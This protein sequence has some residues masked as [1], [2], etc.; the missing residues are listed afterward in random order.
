MFPVWKQ[1]FAFTDV[2]LLCTRT[3]S[4]LH[5]WSWSSHLICSSELQAA[6]CP[7][8][9]GG[10][11]DKQIKERKDVGVYLR[12]HH[13]DVCICVCVCTHVYA[14][15]F[16]HFNIHHVWLNIENH[17]GFYVVGIWCENMGSVLMEEFSYPLFMCSFNK[18]L[19]RMITP[20]LLDG[21]LGSRVWTKPFCSLW[22]NRAVVLK[23]WAPDKT[24][25]AFPGTVLKCMCSTQCPLVPELQNEK[26]WGWVPA[27]YF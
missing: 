12:D 10:L 20:S 15:V 6:S 22:G 17:L 11:I 24:T 7:V 25:S 9:F 5:G 13:R 2:C 19:M 26:L 4:W 21:V 14:I 16:F 3:W 18:C 1:T 27:I 23:V 8:E